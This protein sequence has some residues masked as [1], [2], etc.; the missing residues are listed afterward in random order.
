MSGFKGGEF[1]GFEKIYVPNMIKATLSYA[2][3]GEKGYILRVNDIQF[4][5]RFSDFNEAERIADRY[6]L[7]KLN[8]S[9]FIK[10]NYVEQWG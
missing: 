2:V 9:E 10:N 7:K 5:K 4:K 6:I 1:G 3:T 8:E